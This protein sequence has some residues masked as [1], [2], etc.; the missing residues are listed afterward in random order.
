MIFHITNE[1]EW[2]EALDTGVLTAP[3]L[4]T[5]GF[6]HLCESHQVEGVL[7]RYFSGKENLVR[8]T[9]DPTKLKSEL[10]YE[11]SEQ[12]QEHFPHVYGSIELDA[13]VSAEP[14]FA[15]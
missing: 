7:E 14:I 5:E 11:W 13:I 6:I 3:S 2:K 15:P 12:Q 10:R 8:I 4:V 9:I 1:A